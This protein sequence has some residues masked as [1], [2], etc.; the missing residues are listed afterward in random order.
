MDNL[1]F[2]ASLVASMAWP[3]AAVGMTIFLRRPLI[4]LLRRAKSAEG[5]GAKITFAARLEEVREVVAEAR[6]EQTD[7][8]EDQ[9]MLPRDDNEPAPALPPPTPEALR[10][11]T[12]TLATSSATGATIAAWAELERGLRH[13]AEANDLGW[14]DGNPMWNIHRFTDIGYMPERL[15]TAV[16]ALRKIRNDVAHGLGPDP[17]LEEAASFRSTVREILD[18]VGQNAGLHRWR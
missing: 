12:D 1:Q 3:I 18:V 7:A 2:I 4:D 8:R 16:K 15:A 5:F 17:T 13:I 10:E 6:E 14:D 11:L 9:T